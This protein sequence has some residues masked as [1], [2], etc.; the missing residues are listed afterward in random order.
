M[1]LRVSEYDPEFDTIFI[2]TGDS[3]DETDEIDGFNHHVVDYDSTTYRPASLELLGCAG[4]YLGLT[5]AHGYDAETDTLT[6]GKSVEGAAFKVANGDLVVHWGYAEDDSEPE[7][8]TP[9]AV[10]VKNASKNL[11]PA[12]ASFAANTRRRRD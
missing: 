7:F 10:Q 4:G 5:P 6:I 9:V 8:Y 12:T 3:H 2:S 1:T 11:A